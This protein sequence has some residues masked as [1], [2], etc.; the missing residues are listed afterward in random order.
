MNKN[1]VNEVDM[2]PMSSPLPPR[3]F[4]VLQDETR[5]AIYTCLT[6][7]QKLTVKQLSNF[8]HKGKTT[9]HHHIRKLEEAK[10]VLWEEKKE[11]KKIHKTRYYYINY[12]LI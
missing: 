3:I 2:N 6:V 9:I 1:S 5:L 4:K 7:Y 11:D 12:E 10:I 8:L